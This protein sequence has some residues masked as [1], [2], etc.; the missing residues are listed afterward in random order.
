MSNLITYFIGDPNIHL[1]PNPGLLTSVCSYL[2]A[3][4]SVGLLLLMRKYSV[5][6][7]LQLG[8][9]KV[10][11]ALRVIYLKNTKL[12]GPYN[13]GCKCRGNSMRNGGRIRV[14]IKAKQTNRAGKTI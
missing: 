14:K 13:H 2:T 8:P 7:K 9:D 10:Q 6:L 1:V 5:S 3:A 4:G 11:R 12:G